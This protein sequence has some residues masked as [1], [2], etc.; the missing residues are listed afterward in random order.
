MAFSDIETEDNLL[1]K[2]ARKK[3]MAKTTIS[4]THV[5]TYDDQIDILTTYI[6]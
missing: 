3:L 2:T 6:M 4:Y 5:E 1:S